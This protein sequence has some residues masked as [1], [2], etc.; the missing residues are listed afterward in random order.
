MAVTGSTQARFGLS[1]GVR[2]DR[3]FLRLLR[4]IVS[5]IRLNLVPASQPVSGFG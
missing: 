1:G 4:D 2:L 5:S 3:V